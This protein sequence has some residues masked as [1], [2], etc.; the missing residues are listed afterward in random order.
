MIMLTGEEVE[1]LLADFEPLKGAN[2]RENGFGGLE[3]TLNKTLRDSRVYVRFFVRGG[4]TDPI[5]CRF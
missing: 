2:G 5:A 1:V 3:A 4:I